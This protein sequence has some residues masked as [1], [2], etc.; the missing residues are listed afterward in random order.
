MEKRVL[1]AITCWGRFKIHGT[2]EKSFFLLSFK[3]VILS[4]FLSPCLRLSIREKND[5][6]ARPAR[7]YPRDPIF[8]KA[9]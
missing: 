5:N 1:M 6:D 2:V 7:K 3:C 8:E 9:L 4:I